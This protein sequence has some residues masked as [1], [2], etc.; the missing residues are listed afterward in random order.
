ML[1]TSFVKAPLGLKNSI[2]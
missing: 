2:N 1:L